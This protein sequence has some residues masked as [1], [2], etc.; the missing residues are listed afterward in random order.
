MLPKSDI[1]ADIAIWM[2]QHTPAKAERRKVITCFLKDTGS[3][4]IGDGDSTSEKKQPIGENRQSST[5]AK[6]RTALFILK[7]EQCFLSPLKQ[8]SIHTEEL[9]ESNN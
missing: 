2:G 9:D 5:V 4:R 6:K 7:K 1:K 3:G 8:G